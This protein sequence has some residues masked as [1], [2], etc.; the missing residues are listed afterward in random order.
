MAATN[1]GRSGRSPPRRAKA[2]RPGATSPGGVPANDPKRWRMFAELATDLAFEIDRDGRFSFLFP[3][4][5]LGWPAASLLGQPAELLLASERAAPGV[6]PF[7]AATTERRTV[8]MHRADG[9]LAR[10]FLSITPLRDKAGGIIG[11]RGVAV[12][13]TGHEGEAAPLPDA[14]R[15]GTLGGHILDETR[16]KMAAPQMMRAVLEAL[17]PALDAEG[18]AV[19]DLTMAGSAGP[20]VLHQAGGV[21][22]AV[23]AALPDLLT[24]GGPQPASSVADDGRKLLAG[25]CG[26]RTGEQ[27]GFVFWRGVRARSWNADDRLRA[28]SAGTIIRVVLDHLTRQ[29]DMEGAVQTDGLTGLLLRDSFLEEV[30]RRLDR[31]AFDELPG[32]LMLV[33]L[34]RLEDLKRICGHAVGEA[35][36]LA[37]AGLL[38]ETVRPADLIARLGEDAFA[39][40][41]DGADH[42]AAAERAEQLRWSAPE[43]LRPLAA[44]HDLALT[45][46]IGIAMRDAQSAESL[47]DLLQR[48]GAAMRAVKRGGSGHWRVAHR[49]RPM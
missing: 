12:D 26:A 18:A 2:H 47:H 9:S 28:I 48:A 24:R 36:L 27:V 40:W 41:L 3:K 17:C 39:V 30:S 29:Q 8:W 34:D 16:R 13:V 43:R 15:A 31:L 46:S 11:A 7:V 19:F 22:A 32:T 14:L 10:L 45:M 44:G 20:E 6:N 23:L 35:A 25:L 21:A 42:L 38:R 1:A 4:T 5:A 33:D 37:A 49:S